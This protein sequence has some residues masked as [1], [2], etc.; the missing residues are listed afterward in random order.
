MGAAFNKFTEPFASESLLAER[1]ADVTVRNGVTKTGAEIFI[2]KEDPLDRVQKSITH[3]LG[4]FTP[5]AVELFLRERRGELEAGRVSK[6][7]TGDPGRYGEEFTPASEFASTLT[8]FR[9]MRPDLGTKFYYKGSEY[10]SARSDLSG[11]FRSYAKRNDVTP[12]DIARRYAELNA[13]LKRAQADL[14]ADIQAAQTLGLSTGEIAKQLSDKSNLG[15]EEIRMILS[16][17]FRPIPITR[18]LAEQI[19]AET[20]I[21]GQ[22]RLTPGE[23]IPFDQL[24]ETYSQQVA[25]PLKPEAA[26]PVTP[27]Q[28]QQKE[29]TILGTA[30]NPISALRDLQI[31]QSTR[32]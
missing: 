16:N 27:K 25:T 28:V 6:A 12:S 5:G 14:Y 29:R 10:T 4:G 2:D 18:E 11:A 15:T 31:F 3:V 13:D 1:I 7:I 24:F 20:N 30:S 17:Q 32:D 8:G 9:E 26:A 19:Y 23:D 22:K 21:E